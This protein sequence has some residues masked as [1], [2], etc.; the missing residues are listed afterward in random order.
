LNEIDVVVPPLKEQ[1]EIGRTLRALDD[2]IANNTKIDNHLAATS[3]CDR[4]SVQTL[5]DCL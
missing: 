5:N 1:Q 2:K 4:K 3:V